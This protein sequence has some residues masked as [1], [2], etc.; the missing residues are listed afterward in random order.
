MQVANSY[1]GIDFCGLS[2]KENN[3]LNL[4]ID[5][6]IGKVYN[7]YDI[8]GTTLMKYYKFNPNEEE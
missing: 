6:G 5:N 8:D 3:F 4:F 7:V 2:E 1:D